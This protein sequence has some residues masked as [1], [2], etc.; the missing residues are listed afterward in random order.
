MRKNIM[1]MV[2]IFGMVFTMTAQEKTAAGLYNEGMAMLKEKNYQGGLSALEEALAK[3]EVDENVKVVKLSKKNGSVA[4]ANVGNTR[5]K[6]GQ[7]DEAMT[8]YEKGVELNP[9]NASNY[10]GMAMVYSKKGEKVKA[11]ETF[12]L[13]ADKRIAQ[14]KPKKAKKIYKQTKSIIGKLYTSKEYDL[15][16]EAGNMHIAKDA[17]NAAVH[18]YMSR[19]YTEKGDFTNALKSADL[20]ITNGGDAV[21]DKYYIAKAK[22]LEGSGDKSGA[23]AAYKK[24]TGDKY[25]ES[26]EFQIKKLQG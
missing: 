7:L 2:V 14:E 15:A 6:A 23:I 21:E 13:A 20:A 1:M 9:E 18:Y 24:V 4:A 25:R 5:R 11:V 19:S 17:N 8:F 3:A 22:A 26:A 12:L 16:I 10:R